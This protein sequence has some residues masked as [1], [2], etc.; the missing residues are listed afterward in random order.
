M[1]NYAADW[2]KAKKEFESVTGKSKPKPKGLIASAFNS[3][4]LTSDLKTC[5]KMISAIELENKDM[6]KK[7]KLIDA[8]KKHVPVFAKSA[9]SYLKVLDD[10]VKTEVADNAGEKTVFAKGLKL[11]RSTLDALEKSYEAKINAYEVANDDSTPGALEKATK[12]VQKSLVS[13]IATAKMGSKKIKADPTPATFNEVFNKPDNVARKVQVQLVQA[14]A[15]HKKGAL[16]EAALRRVDPRHIADL[17][18]PWQAGGKGKA[19]ADPNWTETQV[20]ARLAEFLKL[21]ALANAYSDDLEA[22]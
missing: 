19:I 21:L 20:L 6:A 22:A 4:G 8:G 13:T 9:A 5:D 15:A 17:L 11:L 16:P 14:A 3:T 7:K 2:E 1:P 18:T 12:M 10:A